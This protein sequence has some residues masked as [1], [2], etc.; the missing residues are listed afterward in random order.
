MRDTSGPA[1]VSPTQALSE[2]Y[3]LLCRPAATSVP[4]AYLVATC[5][6]QPVTQLY[7]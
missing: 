6:H 4:I 2:N 7:L 5:R 1:S 3:G